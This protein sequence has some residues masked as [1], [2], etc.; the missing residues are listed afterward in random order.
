M[1]S[2]WQALTST[3]TGLERKIEILQ[4]HQEIEDRDKSLVA[5]STLGSE[6]P[7]RHYYRHDYDEVDGCLL[8]RRQESQVQ[9]LSRTIVKLRST[10]I[11]S[12]SLFSICSLFDLKYICC[13]SI[14]QDVLYL[15]R[16]QPKQPA[17]SGTLE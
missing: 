5:V 9:N 11:L 17:F 10:S 12:R 3:L 16:L 2:E 4:L 14:E 15:P 7:L 1:F 13:Y 8:S 6:M